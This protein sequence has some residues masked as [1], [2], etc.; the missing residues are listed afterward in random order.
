MKRFGKTGI[1][2]T[3]IIFIAIVLAVTTYNRLVKKDEQ[4]NKSWAEVQSTYQR[5][6]E[7]IPNLVNT[8]KGISGFEKSTLEAIANARSEAAT[9]NMSATEVTPEA[10][11][12]QQAAQNKLAVAANRLIV[13][14]EDYPV[15][16]GTEAYLALQRQLEGTERRIKTERNRFNEAV[17]DYNKSVRT[18]PGVV[19]ASMMG[20]KSKEGFEA[21]AGADKVVEIKF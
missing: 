14:V 5:R 21:A 15:L 3:A 16:R 11:M 2:I 17:A 9:L 13:N 19:F 18:F 6:M 8:V 1:V 4:V 20:F 12:A 7:L 10:V